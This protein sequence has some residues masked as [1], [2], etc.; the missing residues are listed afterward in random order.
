M[1]HERR[2][3]L[4][5]LISSLSSKILTMM[6]TQRSIYHHRRRHH[7]NRP[8]PERAIAIQELEP[9]KL[10]S[11]SSKQQLR[12]CSTTTRRRDDSSSTTLVRMMMIMMRSQLSLLPKLNNKNSSNNSLLWSS[13]SRKKLTTFNEQ[14]ELQTTMTTTLL[15]EVGPQ[16]TVEAWSSSTPP[17]TIHELMLTSKNSTLFTNVAAGRSSSTSTSTS[18]VSESLP[19]STLI[20]SSGYD[21]YYYDDYYNHKT[22]RRNPPYM[23]PSGC[24]RRIFY[25]LS[26]SYYLSVSTF[27]IVSLAVLCSTSTTMPTSIATT[28]NGFKSLRHHHPAQPPTTNRVDT[29]TNR[30]FSTIATTSIS[31]SERR[32]SSYTNIIDTDGGQNIGSIMNGHHHI[33][34]VKE[35]VRNFNSST[36]NNHRHRHR[37]RRGP[38]PSS[39][40]DDGGGGRGA[41]RNDADSNKGEHRRSKSSS[42]SSRLGNGES[43]SSRKKEM[44]RDSDHDDRTKKQHNG[45]H[46]NIKK[47]ERGDNTGKMDHHRQFTYDDVTHDK[48]LNNN[49]DVKGLRRKLMQLLQKK[50]NRTNATD[51]IQLLNQMMCDHRRGNGSQVNVINC[52]KV[53]SAIGK[54]G[55]QLAPQ[56]ALSVLNDMID[57]YK[58]GNNAIRPNVFVYTSV[59]NAYSR[60]GD[61]DGASKVFKMQVDDFKLSKNTSAQPNIFTYNAMM[62]AWAKS[63]R[64]DAVDAVEKLFLVVKSL[65]DR[66]ELEDGPDVVT[67]NTMIDC[68]SKSGRKE[69]PA[70]ALHYLNEMKDMG[71]EPT[72]ITYNTAMDAHA[73]QGDVDSTIKVFEMMEGEVKPNLKS[74]SIL[75]D[76]WAKSGRPEAPTEAMKLLIAIKDLHA[77]GEIDAPDIITYNRALD[78]H[79]KQGDVDGALN[80]LKMMKGEVKPDILSYSILLDAWAKSDRPEAPAEAMKLLMTIKDLHAAHEIDAPD[81]I[82]YSTALDAYAK[83]GDVDGAINVFEMMEG[84]V[85]PD[86][87]SYINLI[88][89]WGAS[90][91][92]EAPQE[93]MKLLM[94]VKNLHKRGEMVDLNTNVYNSVMN[95]FYRHKM[96]D[97][98][99]KVFQMMGDDFRAGNRNAR[100]DMLSFTTVMGSLAKS[101]WPEAPQKALALLASVRK[102]AAKGELD[103]PTAKTYSKA[104]DAQAKHGYIEG[105]EEIFKMMEEDWLNGN[106]NAT[107]GIVHYNNLLHAW[108]N[109][110]RPDAPEHAEKLLKK[111]KL[112]HA[113]GELDDPPSIQ[114]YGALHK[115]WKLSGRTDKPIY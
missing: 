46:R 63:R 114:T 90:G 110:G 9:T 69:S 79:A 7:H 74:Y 4:R 84:E 61:V 45:R 68:W 65:F 86:L 108:A 109:S 37:H 35:Q 52:T 59:I 28:L 27:P 89:A 102:M 33:D 23:I 10:R 44:K 113:N 25:Y 64:E 96:M 82:T 56:M 30:P 49:V 76:A 16:K 81:I 22:S 38:N 70:K 19:P 72:I 17:T 13:L 77:A 24:T 73:K 67:F 11:S 1:I 78:A 41:D 39:N 103:T 95:V 99:M 32:L 75:M 106:M 34:R 92:Q 58:K 85:K 8:W 42:T 40:Q 3:R 83:Q 98:T 54:S 107:P 100:P 29:P 101:N 15:N 6:S 53:I 20:N 48:V 2:R 87:Q 88:D 94:T 66:G 115:C 47:E 21:Y 62:D 71:I 80:V 5:G 26:P 55:H 111:M 60:K 112:L 14:K 57:L 93:A 105:A 51:L 104:L 36:F 97:G 31:I 18:Y 91:R 12:S 50:P 43:S